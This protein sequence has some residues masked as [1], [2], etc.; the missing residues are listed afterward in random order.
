MLHFFN[1]SSKKKKHFP[2]NKINIIFKVNAL[3]A[4]SQ[5]INAL[6]VMRPAPASAVRLTITYPTRFTPEN[7]LPARPAPVP[8]HSERPTLLMMEQVFARN[9]F[10]PTPTAW[11]APLTA[12]TALSVSK[13]NSSS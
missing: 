10:S 12:H 1:I 11:S 13:T 4:P 9:A 8:Q 5:S 3:N 7:T 2:K 6:N